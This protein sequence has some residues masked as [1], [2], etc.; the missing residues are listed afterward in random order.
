MN[1]Y[2]LSA[3]FLKRN[4]HS[5]SRTLRS[6]ADIR[7]LKIPLYKYKTKGDRAFSYVGPSVLNSPLLYIRNAATSDSFKPTLRNLS[8]QHPTI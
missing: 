7:P 8:L 5:P 6:S 4:L 2:C 1:S 3:H